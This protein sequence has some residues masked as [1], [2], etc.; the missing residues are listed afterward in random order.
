MILMD[1]KLLQ[2]MPS[3]LSSSSSCPSLHESEDE[4]KH[5]PLAPPRQKNKKRL[6]KQLSM[7]ETPRDLAWE[8]RRRQ[9]LR[10]RNASTDRDDLTDEDWNE[11]KGCIELGFAFNEEDGHKLCG[12]LPALDLYF[13]VNRQLSPSPVSTPH[14]STSS[15]S[16]GARS[17]SF[18]S[19]KSESE[20]W[21][22]CSPGEDPKQVKAKLR[23]WAQAVAC[24][25]MQSLGEHKGK[26]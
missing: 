18:E 19:P 14:S 26:F 13:A 23:H 25:V 22:V 2:R 17:S 24:S 7:C 3:S 9:M 1:K 10:P 6:S 11:L 21:K 4:L 12:T 15:S 20:T 16:L 8:K 5:M